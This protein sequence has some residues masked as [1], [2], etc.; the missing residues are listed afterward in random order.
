MSVVEEIKQRVDIVDLISQYVT[1]KRAGRDYMAPCPFHAERTPSF[2]VSPARQSWHCFGACGTG[3]DIFAFIMKKEDCSFREALGVLAERAGVALESRRDPQED[4]RRARLF[5][6]NEAASAF[7]HAQLLDND[8]PHAGQAAVARDYLTER[9]LAPKSVEGFQIG[10]APNTWDALTDFLGA[11][12]FSPKETADAGLCVEGERG[13]YD[14][15]RHRLM[16]PIRDERGRVAGFGGRL[17]PGEALGAGEHQPKYVNT[18]QS[19]IFDKGAILYGLDLAKDAIRSEGRAVIV[20]GYM[21][22]IAAHEH[23]F[24]NV[25]ASMGTALTERQVALLKRYTHNLILALDADAAGSEGMLRGHDVLETVLPHENVPVPNWRGIVRMQETLAAD[26]RVLVMPEGRDPDDV[27][28]SN[29]ELWVGLVDGAMPFLDFR[30]EAVAA[31]HDLSVPR[32]RSAVS[33]ELLPIIAAI[34][35]RVLQSHY[36]QRLARMVQVD[37]ATLR[38]DMRQPVRPRA[39]APAEQED[40][41]GAPVRRQPAPRDRREEFCL[42]LLFRYPVARAEGVVLEPDLFGHSEN[43]ALFETWVGWADTGEPFET[44]LTPDLRPQYERVTGLSLPAYDDDTVVKALRSAVWG[45]EQ[46]RLRL[47]KRASTAVFADIAVGDAASVAERARAAWAA[48][49]ADVE[50]TAEDEA[51]PAAAFVGDMEAGLKVHQ[52]LLEQ[53]N[54]ERPAR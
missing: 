50:H 39:A 15:F 19:P 16:F 11:R 23:G 33:G 27:I 45:I 52:R 43:R 5:E 12:G 18:S 28:R 49:G 30:F 14:R 7:F 20:E 53:H 26:I 34:P 4:A 51:D 22:A 2:H 21:D 32:E 24:A 3:G 25:V 36:M 13:V 40:E 41:A 44:S 29:P 9:R 6:M 46:Q 37:E 8:G 31:K 48:G 38:L 42:A 54:A 1:L 17:L 10:Y 35:D 47:A